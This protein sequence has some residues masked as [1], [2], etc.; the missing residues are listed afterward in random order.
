MEEKIDLLALSRSLDD[1]CVDHDIEPR[2]V[3]MW[4]LEERMITLDDYFPEEDDDE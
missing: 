4:M 2:V 3:I 1:I